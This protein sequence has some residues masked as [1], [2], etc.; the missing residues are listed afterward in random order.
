MLDHID[1]NRTNDSI[2]NLR[3]VTSSENSYNRTPRK[4]TYSKCIG[5]T[6]NK[7]DKVWQARFGKEHLGIFKTEE[8]A[9]KTRLKRE[10]EY[11]MELGNQRI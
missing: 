8:E 3:E 10:K 11:D 2:N 6:Y 5:V 7:R 9:I 1:R 4:D